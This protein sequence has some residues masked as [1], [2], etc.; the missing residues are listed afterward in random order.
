MS[1]AIANITT[2]IGDFAFKVNPIRLAANVIKDLIRPSPWHKPKVF[3]PIF[4]M[5]PQEIYFAMKLSE[6]KANKIIKNSGRI[7]SLPFKALAV[8]PNKSD[9]FWK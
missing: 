7:V 3:V 5:K 9:C 1:A 2:S 4:E 8:Q 6:I